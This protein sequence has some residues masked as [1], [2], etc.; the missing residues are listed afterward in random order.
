MSSPSSAAVE[1]RPARK[2]PILNGTRRKL[3]RLEPAEYFALVALEP[4]DLDTTTQ[5]VDR[6]TVDWLV[7]QSPLV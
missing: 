7:T 3:T 5:P 1:R 6:Q 2:A 4:G